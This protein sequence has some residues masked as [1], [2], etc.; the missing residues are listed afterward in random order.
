[1]FERE[2]TIVLGAGACLDLGYP[3]GGQL[4][5]KLRLE[6]S[7][8]TSKL[9]DLLYRLSDDQALVD[10]FAET[11]KTAEVDSVD[12]YLRYAESPE[13]RQ[14]GKAAV[15]WMIAGYEN[16]A[17]LYEGDSLY[18]DLFRILVDEINKRFD[19][20]GINFVTFNYDRAL[21]ASLTGRVHKTFPG[22]GENMLSTLSVYHVYGSLGSLTARPYG[23][24]R[25][26]DDVRQMAANLHTIG[27]PD[28]FSAEATM[29]MAKLHEADDVIF[30]GYG[31]HELNNEVL[32]LHAQRRPRGL[33]RSRRQILGANG[34]QLIATALHM[35]PR[36]RDALGK[37]LVAAV[38]L[39]DCDARTLLRNTPGFMSRV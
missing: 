16:P 7:E 25:L 24:S 11:I 20:R 32:G 31:F 39:E 13:L 33:I 9:A 26:T 15:A 2:T 14:I 3:S 30:L 10:R 23:G 37:E 35:A 5:A 18:R 1:M 29:A 36:R 27:E 28:F 17:H 6:I 4:L 38:K 8:P 34:Q 21:E 19:A 12:E 22:D